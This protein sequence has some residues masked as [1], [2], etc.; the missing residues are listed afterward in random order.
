MI[1]LKTA[2][3][4]LFAAALG[5]VMADPANSAS[6]SNSQVSLILN[7]GVV[8]MMIPGAAGI[9][10]IIAEDLANVV[11]DGAT[12]R[13]MPVIGRGSLQNV[14]DLKLLR[15]I[16]IAIL[17]ADVLDY[18]KERGI[19]PGI[20]QSVTV[21]AK[22]YNEEFHLLA[23]RDIANVNDLAG[24]IVNVDL[25]TSG[26]AVTASR[27]FD[28][29]QI[30][31]NM[32]NDSQEVALEKLRRGEIAAIA[33]VAGKPAPLF[34]RVTREEGLKLLAIPF[35]PTV[36]TAYAPTRL[37]AGDYPALVPPDRPADTIAVGA[38]LV[39]ADLQFSP[40]RSRNVANFVEAFFTSFQ[41]LLTPGHHPKWQEVNLAADLPGWRR[42]PA[43]E[44]WLQRNMQVA[45]APNPE[46]LRLMFARFVDE[47]LHATGGTTMTPQEKEALFQQFQ[48]WQSSSKN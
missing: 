45:A 21:I 48:R 39:A 26:T 10:A 47:R 44:Q 5:L 8:E 24:K 34:A 40:E 38:V 18:V 14:T 33:F 19:Y 41:S 25:R 36:A 37:T 30:K 15:G 31:T 23:R 7:R 42:Y 16:D 32:A 43:A 22:L 27:L 46:A 35:S 12:R 29:L 6:T 11:D 1:R 4:A 3:T 9:S 17:Q 28:L 2:G 13:I 20:Q